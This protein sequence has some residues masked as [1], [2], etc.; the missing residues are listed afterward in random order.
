MLAGRGE[1]LRLS[2][3][4][5]TRPFFPRPLPA[6]P[7]C[8]RSEVGDVRLVAREPQVVRPADDLTANGDP[9]GHLLAVHHAADFD[10]PVL[11]V[12]RVDHPPRAGWALDGGHDGVPG[13]HVRRILPPAERTPGYG[14]A[15]TVDRVYVVEMRMGEPHP[16]GVHR[17]DG[18]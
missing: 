15:P 6:A 3:T 4:F 1:R 2:R 13:F 11:T 10:T 5:A 16:G 12:L 7:G 14:G 9:V 8:H 18:P 17:P